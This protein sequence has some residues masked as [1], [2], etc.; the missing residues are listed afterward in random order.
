MCISVFKELASKSQ[1]CRVGYTEGREQ[2]NDTKRPTSLRLSSPAACLSDKRQKYGQR[3]QAMWPH[4]AGRCLGEN[5]GLQEWDTQRPPLHLRTLRNTWR[6]QGRRHPGSQQPK[7]LYFPVILL[8]WK[9]TKTRGQGRKHLT[10]LPGHPKKITKAKSR[11]L[12]GRTSGKARGS[13]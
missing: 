5:T 6:S 2:T 9:D 3:G 4:I 12:L 1:I 13:W 10:G 7:H 8:V 11:V